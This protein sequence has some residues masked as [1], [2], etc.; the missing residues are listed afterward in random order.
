MGIFNHLMDIALPLN[1]GCRWCDPT[2]WSFSCLEDMENAPQRVLEIQQEITKTL[3]EEA[4]SLEPTAF[5]LPKKQKFLENGDRESL[6]TK[7]IWL[8]GVPRVNVRCNFM[9]SLVT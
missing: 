9:G 3:S 1:P 6:R 2:P 8:L 5:W 4:I 7:E